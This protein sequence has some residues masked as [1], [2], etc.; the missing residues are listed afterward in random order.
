MPELPEVETVRRGL[1]PLL[2]GRRIAGI[3]VNRRDLRRPL[4]GDFEQQV[5][6]RRITGL[7]RQAKYLLFH[8]DDGLTIIGH[9]GMSGRLTAVDLDRPAQRHD[10]L[11]FQTDRGARIV[12]NDARRFGLFTLCPTDALDAHPLLH[13]LGPDPLGNAFS[14]Q[15]LAAALGER[16]SPV[17]TLLLD[18]TVVAGMGNIYACESLYRAGI[19]PRRLG[20]NV[21]PARAGR[22][23]D[24]IRA[25]L[26]DALAA[27]GSSLRDYADASGEPGYFQHAFRVYGR[28]GEPCERGHVIRRIVQ[29]ARSTFYCPGCQH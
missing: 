24:A 6:G 9:L 22:L 16:R 7:A 28:E 3:C 8:L 17:K 27:S 15:G 21:G 4:P 11:W 23:A 10:H 26:H 18:Q 5:T 12:Y 14:S 1:T 29:G 2:E 20:T 25:V 19:S 13:R